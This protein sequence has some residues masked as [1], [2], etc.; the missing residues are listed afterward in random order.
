MSDL[1]TK[2]DINQRPVFEK[3]ANLAKFP[4][5]SGQ[6]GKKKYVLAGSI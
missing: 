5:T 4:I 2:P 1:L 3:Q 6:T